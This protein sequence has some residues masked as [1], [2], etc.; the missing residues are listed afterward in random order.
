MGI[1][2]HDF[3]LPSLSSKPD[4]I[5]G[6]HYKVLSDLGC[7]LW[8]VGSRT[9]EGAAKSDS[10]YDFLVFTHARIPDV[11][12]GLGYDLNL[13]QHYDPSEGAFNSWRLGSVNLIA[14]D[15]FH[16]CNKFLRA[17]EVAKALRLTDRANRVTLFQ[18]I[19]YA[20]SPEPEAL[21]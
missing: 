18:A 7:K 21:G 15:N 9:I 19:L 17:N 2:S 4:V 3:I 14:T 5:D 13:G 11:F 12:F 10:D 16:F 8:P 1:F 20:K 6:D